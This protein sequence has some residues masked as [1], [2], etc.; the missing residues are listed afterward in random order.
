MWIYGAIDL[1]VPKP[2]ATAAHLLFYV[3]FKMSYGVVYTLLYLDIPTY[4]EIIVSK[5]N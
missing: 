3:Y 4:R 1:C 2:F 5:L